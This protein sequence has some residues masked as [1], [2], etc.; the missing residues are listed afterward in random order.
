MRASESISP[1]RDVDRCVT[2]AEVDDGSG[3]GCTVVIILFALLWEIAVSL[4]YW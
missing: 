4:L 1:S 2:S 3:C